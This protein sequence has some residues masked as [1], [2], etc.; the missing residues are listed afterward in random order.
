MSEIMSDRDKKSYWEQR[1][2]EVCEE[3]VECVSDHASVK[4]LTDWLN[5]LKRKP[6]I[7]AFTEGPERTLAYWFEKEWYERD[8][9]KAELARLDGIASNAQSEALQLK[10]QLAVAREALKRQVEDGYYEPEATQNAENALKVIAQLSDAG[11]K[12]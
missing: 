9:L 4:R 11:G 8:R 12:K 10:S 5:D 2:S 7:H 3:R 6:A 1:H